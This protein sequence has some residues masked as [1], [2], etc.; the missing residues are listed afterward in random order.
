[1]PTATSPRNRCWPRRAGPGS[2]GQL[3]LV[4]ADPPPR[5]CVLADC[6]RGLPLQRRHHGLREVRRRHQAAKPVRD[7]A[8]PV[9]R[10]Q[11]GG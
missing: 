3:E 8:G 2:A 5:Q 7:H 11:A 4:A 1:M 10:C 6:Q 9:H